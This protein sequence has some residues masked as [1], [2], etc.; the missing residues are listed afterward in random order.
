MHQ[1]RKP[2]LITQSDR[3]QSQ[4]CD[5]ITVIIPSLTLTR[6]ICN[7]GILSNGLQ[8]R[9]ADKDYTHVDMKT[10]I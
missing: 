6:C 5:E 4:D 1:P 10:E 2:W 9:L 7:L 3:T 8:K